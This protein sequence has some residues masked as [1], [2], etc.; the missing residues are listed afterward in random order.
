MVISRLVLWGLLLWPNRIPTSSMRG[1]EKLLFET[2]SLMAMEYI[3]L[4]MLV[5]HGS[6]WA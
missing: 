1:Q 2:I 3:N 5:K 6:I 4:R